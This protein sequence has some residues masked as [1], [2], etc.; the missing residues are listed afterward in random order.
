MLQLFAMEFKCTPVRSADGEQAA[1]VIR[2]N[3]SNAHVITVIQQIKK[4]ILKII[5][6]HFRHLLFCLCECRKEMITHKMTCVNLFMGFPQGLS[7][8]YISLQF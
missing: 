2:S 8:L 4:L 3:V 6:F 7:L 1:P 5:Q